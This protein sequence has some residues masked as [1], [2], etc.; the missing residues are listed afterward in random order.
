MLSLDQCAD[1]YVLA[2]SPREA[3]V[4]LSTRADDADSLLAA[5]ARG[6]PLRRVDLETALSTRPQLVV[7]TYGGDARLVRALESRGVRVLTLE[8][9]AD[10]AGIRDNL[11]SVGAAVG[12]EA[13]AAAMVADMDARLARSAGA[14]KGR[15]AIYLTPAGFSAGPGTLADAILR[16]AGLVNA[17]RRRGFVEAPLERLVLDPPK[18]VVTAFF[19]TEVANGGSWTPGRHA[20]M[21]RVVREHAIANL[22]GALIACPN[23]GAAEAAE[24]LAGKAP[25]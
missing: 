18:A 23:W 25:R 3:I 5:R 7:R 14:W 24:L 4:G 11:R 22:P 8:D 21:R 13:G 1:E 15:S 6:L 19:D 12:A 20:L 10:F 2:L 17:E 16:A 9:A